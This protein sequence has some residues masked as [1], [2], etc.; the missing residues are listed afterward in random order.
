MGTVITFPDTWRDAP[1]SARDDGQGEPATII[2]LPVIRIE[3][4]GEGAPGGVAPRSKSR[5]KS[6]R[7]PVTRS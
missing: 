1:A 2:I 6:R 7:S 3:R 5:G 4:H